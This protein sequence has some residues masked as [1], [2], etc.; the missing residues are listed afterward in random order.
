MLPNVVTQPH[1]VICRFQSFRHRYFL[2]LH[3]LM[4]FPSEAYL[5]HVKVLMVIVSVSGS[6]AH[7]LITQYI[8]AFHSSSP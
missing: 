6:F 3:C 2:Y 8:R 5:M 7:V 4:L 1:F